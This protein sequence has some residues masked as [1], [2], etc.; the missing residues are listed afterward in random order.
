MKRFRI[1]CLAF[2]FLFVYGCA[3]EKQAPIVPTPEPVSAADLLADA[4]MHYEAGDYEEAIIAYMSVIEIEP[5]NFDAQLGLGKAYRGAG[6]TEEAIEALLTA[7][8]LDQENTEVVY[9]LGYTYLADE[10][11]ENAQ[12]LT[13]PL[14]QE[15]D[16][17][18]GLLLLM[19]LAGQEKIE[20]VQALMQDEAMAAKLQSLSDEDSLYMGELDE[21]GQRSGKGVALYSGGYVY[22]GNY[23]AGARSGQG[24]W[25]YY[26]GK[27]YFT[28]MW[29]NDAPNGYGEI[30][31]PD[32]IIRGQ[33]KEG[34]EN[35]QMSI[36]GKYCWEEH[37]F[38][39]DNGIRQ[40]VSDYDDHSRFA[41][42]DHGVYNND[43]LFIGWSIE[44]D[45]KEF[46]WGVM[47]WG[48]YS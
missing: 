42:C 4:L 43:A 33:Y 26:D 25:Y 24:I 6:R 20:E 16:A 2:L 40:I 14:W 7:Q 11:W 3:A 34:L 12:A 1:L 22:A 15:G 9:E 41:A 38:S 27:N 8:E 21:N 17:D 19:S 10:Q 23:V 29:E 18:A 47:P 45:K 13:Q 37:P 44:K 32:Q 39:S 31:R 46:L 5:K 28:G 35:G 30:I 48:E 36:S